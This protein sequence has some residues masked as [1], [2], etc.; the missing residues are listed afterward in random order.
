MTF[1]LDIPSMQNGAP[2]ML[3]VKDIAARWGVTVQTVHRWIGDG[4]FPNAINIGQRR[5]NWRIPLADVEAVEQ[6]PRPP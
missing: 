4:A 6:R 1:V 2:V 5:R 3:R